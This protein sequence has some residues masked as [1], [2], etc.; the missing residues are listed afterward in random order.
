MKKMSVAVAST[1]LKTVLAPFGFIPLKPNLFWAKTPETV[2]TVR[3][4]SVRRFPDKVDVTLGIWSPF[5]ADAPITIE[6]ALERDLITENIGDTRFT[7]T[8]AWDLAQFDAG[9][10]ARR[11]HMTGASFTRAADIV[12]HFSD[13]YADAG[14]SLA[15][16][17]KCAPGLLAA[18]PAP[19]LSYPWSAA[20]LSD[21]DMTSSLRTMAATLFA[22]WTPCPGMG[23]GFWIHPKEDG[24]F[25]YCACLLSN[26]TGTVASI[27]YFSAT[28]ADL[29]EPRSDAAASRMFR[30][31]RYAVRR[32]T[33][34]LQLPVHEQAPGALAEARLAIL[35]EL[36]RTPA[37][38]L[39]Q[40]LWPQPLAAV[41]AP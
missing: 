23:P 12:H 20:A 6:G 17:G 40:C 14:V 15:L 27:H 21:A 28:V 35:E 33:L 22:G 2:Q 25:H 39:R 5:G 37:N 3:I 34:A 19:M 26:N 9:D 36:A 8:G 32:G 1:Q 16:A 38:A 7:S 29:T 4:T 24:G 10:V 18:L 30:A 41:A 13:R 11:V 31:T